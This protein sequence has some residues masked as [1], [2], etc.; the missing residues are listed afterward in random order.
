MKISDIKSYSP[1]KDDNFLIDTNIWLYLFCP[2]GNYK[3]YLIKPYE[4][5][6][7]NAIK[8]GSQIYISSIIISEFINRYFRIEFNILNT[9]DSS[10]Y[11]DFKRDYRGS[12]EFLTTASLIKINL[13]K[14]ILRIAKPVEDNFTSIDINK[15]IDSIDQIDFNDDYL[16]ELSS[17]SACK[18]VTNDFDFSLSKSKIQLLTANKKLLKNIS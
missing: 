16:A 9:K 17:I 5:F 18:I 12:K 6:F 13:N 11:S 10:T 4:H 8:N 1:Q 14:N 2:L 7:N 3:Y 15:I